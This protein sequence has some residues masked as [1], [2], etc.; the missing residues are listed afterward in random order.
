MRND[1]DID[2]PPYMEPTFQELL[3][4]KE[5]DPISSSFQLAE[6]EEATAKPLLHH[7]RHG[8]KRQEKSRRGTHS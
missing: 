1:E 3:Q 8:L 4:N 6:E 5:A 7:V 2:R